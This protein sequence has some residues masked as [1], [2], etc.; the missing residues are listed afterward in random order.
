[1]KEHY[2]DLEDYG[3]VGNLETCALIGSDGSVD[4]LCLPYLESPSVFAGLLDIEKGGLFRIRPTEKYRAI[5]E[6]IGDTNVLKTT[7]HSPIGIASITDFMPVKTIEDRSFVTTLFRK[8]EWIRKGALELEI[9]FEPRFDY[10]RAVPDFTPAPGGA[11][12]AWKDRSIFFHSSIPLKIDQAGAH[13]IIR[14][15]EGSTAWF[16]LRYNNDKPLDTREYEAA[17]KRTLDFWNNWSHT[18]ETPDCVFTGPWH[19]LVR[20]SGLILK[21]LTNSDSGAIAAAATTSLPEHIGGV[22]NWDYRF[23]WVRDASLTAQALYHIGHK[24]EARQFREWI[25]GI[26][27][28]ARDLSQLKILYPLGK[29]AVLREQTLDDLSGFRNSGPVRIGNRASGQKQLDIYGELINTIFE[30]TRYGEDI[31][32]SNWAMIREIIDYVCRSWDTTDSGIWEDRSTPKN[33]VY[34]KLMCWVA[35]DRGIRIVEMKHFSAPLD[36]WKAAKDDIWNA[37]LDKGFST[38][39]NSFVRSFG[40]EYLDATSLLIP[41]MGFLPFGDH[42][43]QGTIDAV[44]KYLMQEDGMV[45][46]Y[47]ADDGLPGKEGSFILCS[48]WLV[49]VLSL[50]GRQEEAETIFTKVL[51]Y[52]SPLGL[53]SEEI[54]PASGML[55]GNMPQAFSHIGLINAALHVGIAKGKKH[56]GPMPMGHEKREEEKVRV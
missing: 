16:V 39:L 54:D 28:S 14:A 29:D 10:A 36:Q 20:R 49:M 7:F 3:I 53:I 42:R 51:R 1:M 22:R 5:Q 30:T 11:V 8:V 35:V 45:A 34:S 47:N 18:C 48:F 31:K 41:V 33:Y 25:R 19:S 32:D 9:D 6:Y 26:V 55:L 21:L 17:L 52:M 24:Q 12:A 44:M 38:K 43:V 13:G 40:S 56:G 27:N 2:K 46:R 50:S 4:W 37:I 15:E 23:A